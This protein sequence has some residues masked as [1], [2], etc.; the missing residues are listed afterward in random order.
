MEDAGGSSSA[1]RPSSSPQ[2]HSSP[3]PLSKR[4]S[5]RNALSGSYFDHVGD[6]PSTPTTT[7]RPHTARPRGKGKEPA[8][9]GAHRRERLRRQSSDA[10]PNSH[11]HSHGLSWSSTT[12]DSVVDNLLLSLDNLTTQDVADPGEVHD[13]DWLR[14]KYQLPSMPQFP[15]FST[16]KPAQ[17]PR[18]HTYSS[19]LSSGYEGYG[20]VVADSSSSKDS[21]PPKGRRSNSSSNVGI[22][23]T[24][25]GSVLPVRRGDS[26]RKVSTDTQRR[27]GH[28]TRAKNI[29]SDLDS[30]DYGFSTITETNRLGWGGRRSMSMDDMYDAASLANGPSVL[31]RGRPKYDTNYDEA[32][33]EPGVPAGPRK[34]LNPTATGPVYV[35]AAQPSKQSIRKATTQS[36]LRSASRPSPPI[37]Q[38]I[39]EQASEFVRAN[40]IRGMPYPS[41]YGPAAPS[42][43]FVTARKDEPSPHR[44][45]PGF[46]KR[47]FGGSRVPSGLSDRS[48]ARGSNTQVD[49]SA[50]IPSRTK[51]TASTDTTSQARKVSREQTMAAAAAAY[52]PS[53]NKKPSSFF[54]RRKKS[55]SAPAPPPLPI[56]ANANLLNVRSAEPS[57]SVSSLRKVMDPYLAKENAAILPLKAP[58]PSDYARPETQDSTTEDSDDLDIFHYGYTP[59]PDASLGYRDPLRRDASQK[60]RKSQEQP[61][62]SKMKIKLKKGAQEETTRTSRNQSEHLGSNTLLRDASRDHSTG[63]IGDRSRAQSEERKI[64]PLTDVHPALRE[65]DDRRASKASTGDRIIASEAISP[66]LP[67]SGSS[68]PRNSSTGTQ[69]SG[70][71]VMHQ[72]AGELTTEPKS[73]RLV[74][75]PTEAEEKQTDTPEIHSPADDSRAGSISADYVVS[76]T[77]RSVAD[78]SVY[79]SATSLPLP[80][81]QLEGKDVPRGS[82][83]TA[84]TPMP[85]ALVD[86]G[87]EYRERARK[88]FEGDEED[89]TKAEAA[90]WLGERNT[91]STHTL[92]AY[93]QL[94][95]FTGMNILAALRALCGKLL[96]K[97]ETQQFDRIITAL[98]ERWCECNPYH[99][100]KAQDVVHTIFYS[101][102]LLN[103]DLHLADIGEK[104]SRSAYV[105]NTLPTIRRVVSDAAPNAFDDTIKPSANA[106]RPSIPWTDSSASVPKSP[107]FQQPSSPLER[108]SF[109]APA[110]AP[111]PAPNSK[112]LSIRP[113]VFRNESEGLTPDSANGGASNALV[114]QPWSGPMRAWE[115]EIELVLKSFYG[116]IRSDPLPLL[117][118]P[119]ADASGSERNLSVATFA[120]LKRTGSVVSKAPSDN[121]SYRSKPGLRSMTMGWQNRTNR[122]RPKLYPTSTLGSSSRTSFDDSNSVWSPAQSSSWSKNSFAKTLTSASVNSLGGYLSPTATDF[123]HSI[124][125]ANALSQAIIREEGVGSGGD[126]ESMSVVGLLEDESLALEG[127]P[128]AKEG[129]VKHKHHLE[130]S[131]KK[132]KERNWSECFAVIGKGKLTLFNFNTT[133]KSHSMGRKTLQKQNNNG[134]AASVAAPRVGGGDWMEN[135]EQLHVFILRQTIASVLPPPGY[136]KARPHV[137]ALSLP[138]GAVHLFQV[139][140]PEIANEFMSTANYWSA[141]LSKEPLSGSVS[142]IEYGWSDQVINTALL[143]SSYSFPVSSPPPSMQNVTRHMHSSSGSS[144][145]PPRTSYQSSLRGSFD[146]GFGNTKAR[147]PGDRVQ[148]AEWHPPTQSMMA[149]QLMEVDQLKQLTAYVSNVEAELGRHNELKHAIE[150]AVSYHSSLLRFSRIWLTLINAVLP[151]PLQLQPRHDKLA[152]QIRLPASRNREVQDIHGLL[153]CRSGGQRTFLRQ[154]GCGAQLRSQSGGQRPH[155]GGEGP[156]APPT[157]DCALKQLFLFSLI[158]SGFPVGTLHFDVHFVTAVAF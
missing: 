57:P 124:G 106:S 75:R 94:F 143:E 8:H 97:G 157:A 154:K 148:I 15:S 62:G 138:S 153:D 64:S 134:R 110:P 35:N 79:H 56:N 139:G 146:T 76:P 92:N 52:P 18:T 149:S 133:N 27:V 90:S 95:E 105:K 12:R 119:A 118:A 100:F 111:G 50:T 125:F 82:N 101:L 6:P 74:L 34:K 63:S 24:I 69:D 68:G 104:M 151:S 123:K 26:V 45:R 55:G 20:T 152:A 70:W 155:E 128:W 2:Q 7:R 112:R 53:L 86:E 116:S 65:N 59:P 5:S 13:P 16:I 33:P 4:T 58:K 61:D 132:A 60:P 9:G 43:S 141:R 29:S 40:S 1:P 10:P 129:M 14:E 156:H 72:P 144:N 84:T 11:R 73:P 41:D 19:S 22:S 78:L 115:L 107:G 21:S 80:S 83:D 99:G 49:K 23:N 109:E 31:H 36:D 32:A 51:S 130:T 46:F 30:V 117:G 28:G 145:I 150:L 89:V 67:T 103:T 48:D 127:A 54:R 120:G 126:S 37:P 71:V 44:E 81:V 147:L 93:M 131:D 42:P 47:V 3:I 102:I 135:A 39:Q 91:L 25:D 113:A 85:T 158:L 140:T 137:W 98:S 142:N 66:S 96:L 38:Y 122:S 121:M 87:A 17:R 114:N 108:S 136:T 88:I 77:I